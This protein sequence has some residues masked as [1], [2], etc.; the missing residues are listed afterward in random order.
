MTTELKTAPRRRLQDVEPKARGIDPLPRHS[1]GIKAWLI[2][3]I[4]GVG[5]LLY[6]MAHIATM[7]TAMFLGEAAFERTFEVL[8]TT[9]IFRV[10]DV[11]VLAALILHALNG[12]R[13]VIVEMGF[14]IAKRKHRASL[15][16]TF[17]AAAG[18]FAWLF[19]RAFL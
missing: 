10:F 4:A 13:L 3:R 6:L 8:F 9:P 11:L 2:H 5:L 7:G 1:V 14:W 18:L 16:I 19:T 15:Y 17:G 12:L